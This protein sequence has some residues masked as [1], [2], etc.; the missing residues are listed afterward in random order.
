MVYDRSRGVPLPRNLGPANVVGASIC[1]GR[2]Y[3]INAMAEELFGADTIISQDIGR[4]RDVAV[5]QS[6]DD[7][8]LERASSG[9]IMTAV[10]AHMLATGTIEAW[11][12]TKVEMVGARPRAVPFVATRFDDLILGQGSKYMPS[13]TVE[14]LSDAVSRYNAVGFIGL[15]CQ[16]AAVRMMQKS[17]PEA[18]GKVKFTIA[19]F[20]GGYRDV[21]DLEAVIAKVSGVP[22]SSVDSIGFRAHGNPGNMVV[23]T[24][25]GTEYAYPYSAYGNLSVLPK[26]KR[27]DLCVDATG[28]LADLSCGDAWLPEYSESNNGWSIAICRSQPAARV[29]DE[30]VSKEL[31][32]RE[33]IAVAEVV[34]S[35]R[36]NIVAKKYHQRR[37]IGVY[38]AFGE[39]VPFWDSKLIFGDRSFLKEIEIY[40]RKK[41]LRV[42]YLLKRL[43]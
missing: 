10:A 1:P 20:C 8:I 38:R 25:E 26:T 14:I 37:R 43:A 33:P 16:I 40:L 3:R 6:N 36:Q 21:R 7:A 5:V 29:M 22:L 2:G 39:A 19:N 30:M 11:V 23:Q 28:E 32:S 27:C 4:Y 12:T 42:R 34:E 17:R 41:L 9:G 35:Q 13:T 15:P 18:Y 31:L 24:K